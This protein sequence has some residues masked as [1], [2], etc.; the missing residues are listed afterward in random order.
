MRKLIIIAVLA[1]SFCNV[2]SAE[3]F[4]HVGIYRTAALRFP[5]GARAQAMGGAMA[6]AWGSPGSVRWNPAAPVA[7]REFSA[8]VSYENTLGQWDRWTHAASASV[9]DVTMMLAVDEWTQE[10]Y[11]SD[12]Y[13]SITNYYTLKNQ[14]GWLGVSWQA[15]TWQGLNDRKTI[16]LGGGAH[17]F[18]SGINS[19]YENLH[20]YDIGAVFSWEQVV[21]EGFGLMQFDLGAARTNIIE[22]DIP[23]AVRVG[24]RATWR[25]VPELQATTTMD[26]EH[27]RSNGEWI[28]DAQL[29]VGIE[30]VWMDLFAFRY[31][32]RDEDSMSLSTG[33]AFG[34]GFR[35]AVFNDRLMLH[36]D[37]TTVDMNES[38][39]FDTTEVWTI[40]ASWLP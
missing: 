8:E 32:V 37:I 39:G 34:I 3:Q 28:D 16:M 5:F 24:G 21:S 6:S 11:S 33:R 35:Y 13:G 19:E 2:V 4:T 23:A 30:M 31:G 36:A 20:D 40:G 27:W 26:W 22:K 29:S 14:A 15:L 9:G 1:A 12:A 18:R 38:Y 10:T 17:G 7:G 25:V